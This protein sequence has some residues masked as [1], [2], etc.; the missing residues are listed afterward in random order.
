MRKV[1]LRKP[2]R[3]CVRF[4]ERPPLE[5]NW[6]SRRNLHPPPNWE[7]TKKEQ[8]AL[9]F[10]FLWLHFSSQNIL[11]LCVLRCP[12]QWEGVRQPHLSILMSQSTAL[13]WVPIMLALSRALWQFVSWFVYTR[14]F[15]QH[16]LSAIWKKK[17][18]FSDFKYHQEGVWSAGLCVWYAPRAGSRR[19]WAVVIVP[20]GS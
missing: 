12:G 7:Q 20:A 9:V 4:T 19:C 16:I 15:L 3:S 10:P 1:C 11:I 18:V 6:S 2:V 8:G 17:R 5:N 13:K 14:Q